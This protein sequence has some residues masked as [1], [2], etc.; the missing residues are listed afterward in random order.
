MPTP[1][2]A[3]LDFTGNLERPTILYVLK[4]CIKLANVP[5]GLHGVDLAGTW[6][7][8]PT[9]YGAA[10]P[11]ATRTKKLVEKAVAEKGKVVARTRAR[12]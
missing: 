4:A 6:E 9:C 7:K 11:W 1:D 12:V 2:G 5:Q 8:P 3:V 10:T